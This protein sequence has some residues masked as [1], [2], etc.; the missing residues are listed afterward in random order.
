M[1]YDDLH[2]EL[3]S[4]LGAV[5]TRL[6]AAFDGEYAALCEASVTMVGSPGKRLRPLMLLLSCA[7]FGEVT[8]RA[9]T[10]ASLIEFLH[11]ASLAHDDVLDEA[12]SRRGQPSAPAQERRLWNPFGVQALC[13]RVPTQGSGPWAVL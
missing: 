8:E 6:Q 13:A 7:A 2:P 1:R 10:H 11:T 4:W 3:S 12:D 5:E 9:L